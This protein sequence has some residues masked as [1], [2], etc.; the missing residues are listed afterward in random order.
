MVLS[1]TLKK[2]S[3]KPLFSIVKTTKIVAFIGCLYFHFI[4]NSYAAIT[5]WQEDINKASLVRLVGSFYQDDSKV[6]QKKLIIGLQFK[7][8]NG[9]KIYGQ[10]QDGGEMSPTFDLRASKNYLSH[11]IVWPQPIIEQEKIGD[12]IIKYATYHNE[13][14]LPIEVET[15]YQKGLTEMNVKVEYGICNNVCIPANHEFT[16]N[17]DEVPS[18]DEL[19]LI[20]KFYP[21]RILPS[22]QLDVISNEVFSNKSGQLQETSLTLILAL[23]F[24]FI[25]GAIL[26]IMPCVLPVLSIK[27]MMIIN[28]SNAKIKRIRLS[29]I[30]TVFGIIF[31]FMLLAALACI[32]KITSDISGWGLQF[33]NPYFLIFLIVVLTLFIA[34][35]LG[36]FEI[37]FSYVLANILNQ[38]VS[39]EGQRK[40]NIFFPNFLSGVLAVM[41]S[42]PCSAPFLGSAIS[43]ALTGSVTI[44]ILIFF[45]IALG[46]ALPY[47]L[48]IMSPQLVYLLPKPGNWMLLIKKIMAVFLTLTVIWLI[49]ILSHHIGDSLTYL[50]LAAALL[51]LAAFYTQNKLLKVS[52]ITFVIIALFFI[53]TLAKVTYTPS[54]NLKTHN[55]LWQKFDEAQ[56]ENLVNSGKTIIVDV[57]A[58]WCLTCKLN[59]A[60][61]LNNKEVLN[62][63]MAEDIILMR[64]DIT[65]PDARVMKYL[66]K[67]GRFAIPFNAVYGPYAKNGLVTNELLTKKE[68]LELITKASHGRTLDE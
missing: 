17:L 2:L 24:A 7:L 11:N 62:K 63:I 20:Q 27:L 65:K 55:Q 47:L 35:V 37:N 14:I 12:E 44:I 61:V 23:L 67:K 64:A 16:L 39:L 3:N 8:G 68:L 53:P 36:R 9:W 25:G 46:F 6:G 43:F 54:S 50:V 57:T 13:I 34:N 5:A 49:Y 32:I 15:A 41:L 38:K 60:Q 45:F 51:I 10:S 42:T 52:L 33:Q 31:C 40:R 1:M 30:Y 48:L 29:F 56:L 28:K 59:K 58:D 66:S 22:D 4:G 19:K 21:K 26:N 18:L